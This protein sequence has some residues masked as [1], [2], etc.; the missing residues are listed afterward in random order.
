MGIR[1]PDPAIQT[2]PESEPI[3][4]SEFERFHIKTYISNCL[5]IKRSSLASSNME[6]FRHLVYGS[7]SKQ[8]VQ[9]LSHAS[10]TEQKWLKNMVLHLIF[11]PFIFFHVS[12]TEH[13][14][15]WILDVSCFQ[16]PTVLDTLK[17]DPHSVLFFNGVQKSDHFATETNLCI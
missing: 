2:I 4:C 8:F 7:K 11:V 1:N 5:Y 15:V 12:K 13:G 16:I 3:P 6:S 10:K 14:H 17:L 9:I